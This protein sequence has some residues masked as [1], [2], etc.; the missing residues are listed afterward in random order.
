ML[1]WYRSLLALRRARPELADPRLDQVR[2]SH[3]EEARWLL[4]RRGTLRIAANLGDAAVQIPLAAAPDSS[5]APGSSASP[6]P[7]ALLLASASD[8]S[9]TPAEITLPPATFA[10]VD[11]ASEA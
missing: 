4:T 6:E 7:P 10:V 9:V 1:E 2:V 8:I 11:T 5:A 3:N